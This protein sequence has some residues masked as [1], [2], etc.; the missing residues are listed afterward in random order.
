MKKVILLVVL[1]MGLLIPLSAKTYVVTVRPYTYN[2]RD[3]NVG[4][5]AAGG[6]GTTGANLSLFIDVATS[7]RFFFISEMGGSYEPSSKDLG[8]F[9]NFGGEFEISRTPISKPK[10][11]E[12]QGTVEY[13]EGSD[14]RVNLFH[15]RAGLMAG[16]YFGSEDI[17]SFPIFATFQLGFDFPV[18]T[19]MI[20]L[21]AR[22]HL[23]ILVTPP[24]LSE[25]EQIVS[26]Y[27]LGLIGV[28]YRF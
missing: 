8:G 25:P 17:L 6:Y 4:L 3:S 9:V 20:T 2:W 11:I 27:C 23:G 13:L 19:S 10:K 28:G 7:E 18:D 22:T 15:T 1:F 14:S 5:F 12:G 16:M 21:F 24:F 26:P